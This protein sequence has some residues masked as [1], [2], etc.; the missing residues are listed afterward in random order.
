MKKTILVIGATG[1]QGGSVARHLLAR[2][3]FAVRAF[4]RN[5]D[6]PAAQALRERGAEIAAGDLTDRS[7][8]RAALRGCY[9]TFGVTNYWEHFER[10][11]EHGRNLINA[12]AGSEV[13]HFVFSSLPSAKMR[14]N[15]ELHVPHFDQKHQLENY[16]RMLGIA[17]TFVHVAFYFDN[18]LTFFPPRNHGDGKYRFGFPQGDVPLAAV[19]VEDMGGVVTEI[20]DRPAEFI[21]RTVGIVGDDRPAASYA[22]ALSDAVGH[23]VHYDPIPRE[24]F[25]AF[26]FPGAADLADMFEFNR[27]Y[28]PSRLEDLEESRALY[29]GMQTF[30]QWA[31]A[32]RD[33]LAS[34]FS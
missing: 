32:N 24:V 11:P 31:A 19:A 4:T 26:P 27:R 7:S 6:S 13:E 5:P 28:I 8:L 9:G 34:L 1:A 12:V 3:N 21:G 23:P 2:G 25:A 30:E 10:E 15:G 16:A 29:P 22:A 20:F 14:S 33:A 17:S 18:F